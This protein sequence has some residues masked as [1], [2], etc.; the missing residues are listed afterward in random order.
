MNIAIVGFD[1]D[2]LKE[3]CLELSKKLNLTFIDFKKLF[4]NY[5]LET[6]KSIFVENEILQKEESK[7]LY[8]LLLTSFLFLRTI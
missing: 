1:Y 6:G 8:F 2:Y 4:E 5:L 3:L 7:L